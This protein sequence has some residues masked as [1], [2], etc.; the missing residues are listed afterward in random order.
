MIHNGAYF[1][2]RCLTSDCAYENKPMLLYLGKNSK[3][4]VA[5]TAKLSKCGGCKRQISEILD[6]Y[7]FKCYWTYKG[8]LHNGRK[9][10]RDPYR[11]SYGLVKFPHSTEEVWDWLIIYVAEYEINTQFKDQEAQT[12]PSIF[13]K[14]DER[15]LQIL[16][17]QADKYKE[18]Y[19]A[20]KAQVKN[21][22]NC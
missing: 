7:F 17:E 13:N 15:S 5:K 12:E 4:D 10:E 11:K 9:I 2:V 16:V 1:S 20:L 8:Q 3:F 14:Y 21:H 18:K 6:I 19:K 22:S